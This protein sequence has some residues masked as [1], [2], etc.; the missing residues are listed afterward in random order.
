MVLSG[1]FVLPVFTLFGILGFSYRPSYAQ[2]PLFLLA[3]VY[4]AQIFY[5]DRIERFDSSTRKRIWVTSL[6]LHAPVLLLAV[7][8]GILWSAGLLVILAPELI[9]A[10]LHITGISLH[11]RDSVAHVGG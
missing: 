1:S 2:V 5:L 9:S 3:A 11:N 8:G 6:V 4:L 10:A 7:V